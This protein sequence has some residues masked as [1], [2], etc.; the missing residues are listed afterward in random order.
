MRR[1][2]YFSYGVI[3]YS[4]F[5]VVFLYAIGFIGNFAVPRTLDSAP[6]GS[7]TM[8]LVVNTVLLSVFA[9]QHSVMARPWFKNW[10]TKFVPTPVER[11]TY[12]LFS[13]IAMM[14]MFAFWQPI[15]GTIWNVQGVGRMV[16]YSMFAVGWLTVLYTTTLVNH[17]DLFRITAGLALLA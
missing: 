9:I 17:F 5:L 13:N 11:S 3:C 10:W 12:V 15:G 7:L 8:A 16:L 6:V 4:M 2:A 1:V 14:L